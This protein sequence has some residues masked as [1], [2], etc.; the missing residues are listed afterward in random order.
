MGPSPGRF[1]TNAVADVNKPFAYRLVRARE[2]CQHAA[3]RAVSQLECNPTAASPSVKGPTTTAPQAGASRAIVPLTPG[4]EKG[5]CAE[6]ERDELLPAR[7]FVARSRGASPQATPAAGGVIRAGHR[8]IKAGHRGITVSPVVIARLI[9]LTPV[10]SGKC[11]Q[12]N[13]L[14]ATQRD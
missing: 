5:K 13:Y 6:R 9:T 12:R 1:R 10:S 2:R 14:L 8:G 7:A 4:Q 3:T 11:C